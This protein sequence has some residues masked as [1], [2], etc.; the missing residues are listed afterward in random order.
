MPVFT[1]QAMDRQGHEVRDEIEATSHEEAVTLIRKKGYYPTN[2]KQ[3]SERKAKRSATTA[4]VKQK[5]KTRTFGGGVSAKQLTQFTRQL[6]TLTDAG[7]PLVRSL[8]IL[9][10]Q[11]KPGSLKNALIDVTDDVQAGTSLSE[12]LSKHPKIFDKLYVNLVRAGEAGGV[13]DVI[14]QRLADFKEKAEKLKREVKGALIYPVAVMSIAML[15]LLGIM[16]FIIPQFVLM[17]KE[18]GLE[19]G[20]PLPT[21]ILKECSDMVMQFWF[22]PLLILVIVG[23][24]FAFKMVARTEGGA[25]ALD[26]FKIKAPLIGTIARKAVISRFSRTL[27]TLIAS[28]VPILEAL[29][30]VKEVTGNAVIGAAVGDVHDSIREGD[31]IAEPLRQSGVFDEMVINMIEVGEETGDL[32]KMLIKVADTYDAEVDAA[33]AG[34]MS[35]FEPVLIIFLGATVGFIVVA[36]FLPLI[37][38]MTKMSGE[39]GG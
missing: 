16:R 39:A 19:G 12:A 6:S 1:Y 25:L 26:R 21:V 20:L 32:D 17:F 30:I 7:L 8:K 36:L 34:L 4:V 24:I 10:S 18:M 23:T 14:L 22:F 28:G 31:T 3:K 29:S 2:V 5:G 15:I 9:E 11:L 27:G 33:V 35:L 37:D 38:M 13:L